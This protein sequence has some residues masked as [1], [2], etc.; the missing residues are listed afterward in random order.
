MKNANQAN[1]KPSVDKIYFIFFSVVVLID[2]IIL[3]FLP[4]K[5]LSFKN[6]FL[7]NKELKNM[8]RLI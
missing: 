7:Q 4:T 8:S 1:V 5:Q 3:L 6:T 2:I